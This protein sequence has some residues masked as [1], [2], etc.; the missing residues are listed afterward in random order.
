MIPTSSSPSHS[1]RRLAA[2]TVLPLSTS[3][4]PVLLCDLERSINGQ[5]DAGGFV[6]VMLSFHL[7]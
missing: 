1:T 7:R 6:P 5:M 2:T 4:S 3:M